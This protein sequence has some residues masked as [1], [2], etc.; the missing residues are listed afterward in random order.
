MILVDHEI[1]K[2]VKDGELVIK[3]FN[4][5][6]VGAVSYDVTLSNHFTIYT[7][8]LFD[9]LN[10]VEYESFSI[11]EDECI[12]LVPFHY[13]IFY[14]QDLERLVFRTRCQTDLIVDPDE[15]NL[16]SL[17][18]SFAI[19]S[20]VLAST[21]EYIKLP[22]YISAEYTG[23]SS[24]GRIFLQSHQT[25]GW[26]DAGFEGTVTLELIALDC[27]VILHPNM[28]IGQLIFYKHEKCDVPY[29]KRKSSKYF[30]QVGAT[31]SRLHL[32]YEED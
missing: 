3:P 24:L 5:E 19:F 1:K 32:D 29:W 6:N 30:K 13:E 14:D 4:E 12:I 15:I 31:P 10:E 8:Q 22:D 11:D 26:L 23:R 20:A 16:A 2:A 27:P 17:D 7:N 21:N 25:A 9:P 28:K 18:D